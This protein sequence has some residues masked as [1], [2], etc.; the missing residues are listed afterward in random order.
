MRG[1]TLFRWIYFLQNMLGSQLLI[2][3]HL[4]QE[5][6]VIVFLNNIDAI[7]KVKLCH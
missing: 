5:D 2:N 3:I 1:R 7:V 6:T 4:I